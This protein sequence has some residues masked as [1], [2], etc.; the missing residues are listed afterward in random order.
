MSPL[1]DQKGRNKLNCFCDGI[2]LILRCDGVYRML[3]SRITVARTEELWV[4]HGA[5]CRGGGVPIKHV[6]WKKLRGL[7]CLQLPSAQALIKEG[8]PEEHCGF[9]SGAVHLANPQEI[10]CTA[11]GSEVHPQ[12]MPFQPQMRV[13]AVQKTRKFKD[14]LQISQPLSQVLQPPQSIIPS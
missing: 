10:Q 4:F 3:A 11:R 1:G 7:I 12:Y 13:G 14:I 2:I 6:L 5:G 8:Q 9:L